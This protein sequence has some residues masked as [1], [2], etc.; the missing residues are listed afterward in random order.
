MNLEI[1]DQENCQ[2]DR[3][4]AHIIVLKIDVTQMVKVTLDL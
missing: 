1:G 3:V 2:F 4:N